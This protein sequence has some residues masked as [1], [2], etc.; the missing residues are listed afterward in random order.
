VRWPAGGIQS[1]TN[2]AVNRTVS[3]T[4]GRSELEQTPFTGVP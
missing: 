3:I 2:V 1:W 4:E